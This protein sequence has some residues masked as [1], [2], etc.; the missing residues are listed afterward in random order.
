MKA[1]NWIAKISAG[2]GVLLILLAGISTIIYPTTIFGGF[3]HRVN[4]FHAA[5]S[6]F[7]ITI[8]VLIYLNKSETKK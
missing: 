6:F 2:I 3:E 8:I 1:L 7:L 5:N 4:Y